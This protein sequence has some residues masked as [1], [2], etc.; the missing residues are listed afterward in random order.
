MLENGGNRS[1]WNAATLEPADTHQP[2]D[3]AHRVLA[4]AV[5]ASLWLVEQTQSVVVAHGSRCGVGRGSE[6]TNLHAFSV[7]YDL[8]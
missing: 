4:V 8:T 5:P 2:N 3:V 6:L 7:N 1:E